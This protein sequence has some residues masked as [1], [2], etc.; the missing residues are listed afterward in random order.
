MFRER[1]AE[2]EL[3]HKGGGN[4]VPHEALWETEWKAC[5]YLPEQC[6]GQVH[7]SSSPR[8]QCCRKK[9]DGALNDSFEKMVEEEKNSEADSFSAVEQPN[10][11]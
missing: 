4:V 2:A 7:D 1:R 3:I 5:P 6:D 9:C 11:L 10:C 8:E